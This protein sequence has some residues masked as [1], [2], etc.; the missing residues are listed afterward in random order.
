[1]KFMEWFVDYL[2]KATLDDLKKE[3]MDWK[4]RKLYLEEKYREFLG[5]KIKTQCGRH[6]RHSR[7]SRHLRLVKE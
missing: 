6:S 1:M 2:E 5:G 7:H 3:P 4:E